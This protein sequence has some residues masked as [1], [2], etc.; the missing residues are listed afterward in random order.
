MNQRTATDNGRRR[1]LDAAAL[2]RLPW[3]VF[4]FS[5]FFA[6]TVN[7][8]ATVLTIYLVL[9]MSGHQRLVFFYSVALLVL[10]AMAM[11]VIQIGR[12]FRPV[13]GYFRKLIAGEEATD[14]EYLRAH[15]TFFSM[16]RKRVIQALVAWCLLMPAAIAFFCL[17]P[18]FTPT[19]TA[20]VVMT[21][22]F[23]VNVITVGG[24]YYLSIA[25]QVRKISLMGVFDRRI[26]G[27]KPLY[28]RLGIVLSTVVVAFM[29]L[30]CAVMVPASFIM[31]DR[32][33]ER[34]F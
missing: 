6:Y 13:T 1:D 32:V 25:Y 11:T 27:A 23:A 9:P 17:S 5:D 14:E 21:G 8:P 22:L 18:F 12:D 26:A 29:G 3:R 15:E 4:F 24:A 30:L 10:I 19:L 31:V 33:A 34:S 16:P 20:K 28:S 7:I 2:T